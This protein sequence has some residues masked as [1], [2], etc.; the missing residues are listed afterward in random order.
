MNNDLIRGFKIN[1]LWKCFNNNVIF[2]SFVP[3][4]QV[5]C[6]RECIVNVVV[7]DLGYYTGNI[8]L[9]TIIINFFGLR[10]TGDGNILPDGF[11]SPGYYCPGGQDSPSDPDLECWPGYY[12][13]AGSSIPLLCENGTYQQQAG[14][15]FC[16]VC[17]AG[18]Y[19]DPRNGEFSSSL[20]HLQ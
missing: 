3:H 11:C 12:C 18:F 2:F 4:F 15:A 17:P 6:Q 1:F 10:F 5:T 9:L 14:Q 19:C 16:D 7:N 20:Q 13:P 8:R